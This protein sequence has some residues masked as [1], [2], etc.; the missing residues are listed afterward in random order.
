[1]AIQDT[2]KDLW[3]NLE[4][5]AWKLADFLE[6]KGVP[7]ASFCESKGV[8]PLLLFGGILMLVILIIA[9]LGGAGAP[10]KDAML[11]VTVVDEQGNPVSGQYLTLTYTGGEEPRVRTD[12]SGEATFTDL[13]Y[14]Q[15]NIAVDSE[16]Y[17]GS[18][19]KSI[20][21]KQDTVRLSVQTKKGTLSVT[22]KDE[23]GANVVGGSIEIVELGKT[24][25]LETEALNGASSYEFSVPA[26]VTYKIS[27]KS[28]SGGELAS[29][30]KKVDSGMTATVELGIR[31]NAAD[32]ATVTVLVKDENGNAVRNATVNLRNSRDNFVIGRGMT[33][34]IGQAVFGEVAIQTRVYPEVYVAGTRRYGQ[35]GELEGRNLA[36]TV[37]SIAETIEVRLPLNGKVE[38]QVSDEDTRAAISGATVQMMNKAGEAIGEAKTTNANGI[39]NFAGF[40]ENVYVYPVV[41]AVGYSKHDRISEAQPIT[42]SRT[43]RFG[44]MLKKD[45]SARL[46]LINV[47]VTDSLY[48]EPLQGIDA[49]LSEGGALLKQLSNAKNVTFQADAN[50]IYTVSLHKRG[51]LYGL[52][53]GITVG[54]HEAA[55]SPATNLNSGEVK[56]CT[57]IVNNGQPTPARSRVQLRKSN[58]PIIDSG[59]TAVSGSESCIVFTGV[60][61]EWSVYAHAE[62][63]GYAPI[64]SN[65][66]DVIARQD[67]VTEINISFNGLPPNAAITG[68]VKV[69]VKDEKGNAVQGAEVLLYDADIEGPSWSGEYRKT[70]VSDGCAIF[71]DLPSTKTS[72]DGTLVPVRVYAVVSAANYATYNGKTEGNTVE[73]QPLL[74]TPLNV[75]LGTGQSICVNVQNQGQAVADATVSLCA[76]AQCTQLLDTQKTGSDG[77]AVFSSDVQTVT[78]KVV[79]NINRMRKQT[80]Q[81][82]ALA[83]VT[84]GA[85][86]IVDVVSINTYVTLTLDG[87][88]TMMEVL[89]LSTN[90]IRFIAKIND[91]VATGGAFSTGGVNKIRGATGEEVQ[92]ELSSQSGNGIIPS[93]IM[94]VDQTEGRYS[95]PFTV[96]AAEG[97]YRVT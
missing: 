35:L 71:M 77:H 48:R 64:D 28:N 14:T 4:E 65:P 63:D 57:Y 26:G 9:G 17:V 54:T 59:T 95:I 24:K 18:V 72:A 13:P 2:L 22:V 67:G 56:V 76:N 10:A 23:A 84:R 58:G 38:V 90:E 1:M 15:V 88:S 87:V 74:T 97:D 91:R 62:N 34:A 70:T 27:V 61:E 82:F 36:K 69:C 83:Q 16:K 40:E 55:L 44:V 32:T 41:E 68:D 51:Y 47:Q 73:V 94:A 43:T 31:A 7:I 60:P 50:K 37:Q 39:V 5:Y 46:S 93:S 33:N 80:I 29:E 20:T 89:P 3:H 92:I 8:S 79:T 53:E 52:L 11:K 19:S 25:V 86:G 6:D 78:V 81:N 85:C 12:L 45:A 42:Y 21:Q 96:P 49:V 75:R 30:T 66:E